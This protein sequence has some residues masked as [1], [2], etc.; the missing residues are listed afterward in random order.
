MALIAEAFDF[1]GVRYEA[2]WVNCNKKACERC[3]HGPYWYA[4]ISLFGQRPVVRYVGKQLKGPVAKYYT[5]H[6]N[7]ES[8]NA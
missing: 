4:I 2:R 8:P 3:P 7:G 5:D 1:R 6:Y